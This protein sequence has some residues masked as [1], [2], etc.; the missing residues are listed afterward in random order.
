[1]TNPFAVSLHDDGTHSFLVTLHKQVP[2]GDGLG[3][4][5]AKDSVQTPCVEGRQLFQVIPVIFQHSDPYRSIDKMQL[6]YN[7]SLV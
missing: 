5:A 3:S 1:M 2:I 4:E 6:W 7:M